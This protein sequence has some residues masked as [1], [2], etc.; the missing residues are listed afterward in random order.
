LLF[1]PKQDWR[2]KQNKTASN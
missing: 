1:A 2:P